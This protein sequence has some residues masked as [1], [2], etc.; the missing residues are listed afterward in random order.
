MDKLKTV[1][2]IVFIVS[3]A[4][5]LYALILNPA[6]WIVYTIS[7]V[8]IPLFI[9]SLGLISMA[10]GRKEDEEDKIKEPFIGY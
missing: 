1:S 3:A 9:L 10:R 7:L 8:F 6:S 2:W 5:I 4:A